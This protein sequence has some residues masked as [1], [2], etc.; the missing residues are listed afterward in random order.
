MSQKAEKTPKMA[1][2]GDFW[3][4]QAAIAPTTP[5]DGR[6]SSTFSSVGSYPKSVSLLGLQHY[7][8]I[9]FVWLG[10]WGLGVTF[11][12]RVP[13]RSF[14]R[15]ATDLPPVLA[16]FYVSK[17]TF[18]FDPGPTAASTG[19]RSVFFAQTPLFF[20]SNPRFGWLQAKKW[21][22]KYDPK[23]EKKVENRFCILFY[24]VIFVLDL[25][26]PAQVQF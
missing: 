15:R 3:C 14:A 19:S 18:T 16:C 8:G 10:K 17:T 22:K 12:I 5:S 9:P 20:Q 23:I 25:F 21:S 1:S 6:D 13:Y 11:S 2:L 4:V 7:I 24:N 26:P